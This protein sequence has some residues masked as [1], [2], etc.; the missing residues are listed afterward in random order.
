MSEAE[1]AKGQAASYTV[2][3]FIRATGLG[4]TTVYRLIKDGRIRVM[5]FGKKFLIPA[6]VV[7]EFRKGTFGSG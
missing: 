7:E 2:A 4:R 6:S 5:R 3:E 1:K